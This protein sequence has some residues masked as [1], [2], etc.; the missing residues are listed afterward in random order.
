MAEVERG[1]RAVVRRP[2]PVRPE[3]GDVPEARG[4]G[5]PRV[6]AVLARLREARLPLRKEDKLAVTTRLEQLHNALWQIPLDA[7]EPGLRPV[8]EGTHATRVLLRNTAPQL[9]SHI[10]RVLQGVRDV[11][12]GSDV[13]LEKVEQAITAWAQAPGLVEEALEWIAGQSASVE[14]VLKAAT[15]EPLGANM[16]DE[17][18]A[19]IEDRRYVELAAHVAQLNRASAAPGFPLPYGAPGYLPPPTAAV[20]ARVPTVPV[21]TFTD[22]PGAALWRA[23]G[24]SRVVELFRGPAPAPVSGYALALGAL[25]R[26]KLVRTLF[27][28]SAIA[29]VGYLLF[30]EKFIGTPQ[31]MAAVFVWGFT[32]DVSADALM[33]ILGKNFKRA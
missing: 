13:H 9:R 17:V 12:A 33:D 31:D 21:V 22:V 27:V 10:L 19:L 3:P 32:I 25:L 7:A 2:G 11:L 29:V 23:E 4:E 1:Q 30:V 26:A 6:D 15:V 16:S 18:R 8:L 28:G 14:Q 5:V 20:A 24:L